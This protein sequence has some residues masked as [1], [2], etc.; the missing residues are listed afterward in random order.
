VVG[1]GDGDAYG[2]SPAVSSFYGARWGKRVRL[3]LLLVWHA[4][5]WT[6]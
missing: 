3:G 1:L 5:I 6:I 4:V 2:A